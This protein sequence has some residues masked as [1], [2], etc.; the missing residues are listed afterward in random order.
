MKTFEITYGVNLKIQVEIKDNVP[1]IIQAV[2]GWGNSVKPNEFVIA[3]LPPIEE[4]KEIKPAIEGNQR[5]RDEDD[6][7]FTI[8]QNDLI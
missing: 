2:D 1:E 8:L 5:K 6:S 7:N 4:K 3:E